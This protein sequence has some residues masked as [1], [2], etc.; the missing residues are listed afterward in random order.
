MMIRLV[1]EKDFLRESLWAEPDRLV[2]LM[3]EPRSLS[4]GI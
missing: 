4:V 3:H 2:R 1:R